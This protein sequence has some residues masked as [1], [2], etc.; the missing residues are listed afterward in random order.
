MKGFRH[1]VLAL[2]CIA[3]LAASCG[4]R[5]IPRGKLSDIYVE[6]F[7]TDQWLRENPS[8]NRTADTLLVYEPIF[9][10]FG[11]STDDYLRSQEYYLRDPDRYA[12][13]MR[14]VTRKLE[15]ELKI[16]KKQIEKEEYIAGLH[17][18]R[19]SVADT[20]LA[21]FRRTYA[22]RP[23][24]IVDSLFQFSLTDYS[25][26]TVYDGPRMIVWS[27]TLLRD[28]LAVDSLSVADSLQ[29]DSLA[30]THD[31]LREV[32]DSGEVFVGRV[33]IR[34]PRP[35]VYEEEIEPVDG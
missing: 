19:M 31:I 17:L 10:R 27:D 28:T 11:Y 13:L 20:L 22:G 15:K 5:V 4:P 25:S 9:E 12:K 29:L 21:R 6:M 35:V 32:T 8:I 18:G 3:A 23:R 16:I 7:L 2:A 30:K 1:T 26:D 14:G 24:V 34:R 33:P